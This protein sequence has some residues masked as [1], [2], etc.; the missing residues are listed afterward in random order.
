MPNGPEKVQTP[1]TMRD[2]GY[3]LG[4]H[5]PRRTAQLRQIGKLIR[6]NPR[7]KRKG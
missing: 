2:F 4:V 6:A 5:L 3:A 1:K 7:G